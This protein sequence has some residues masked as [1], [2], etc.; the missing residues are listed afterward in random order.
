M[1]CCKAGLK[2]LLLG[3]F[4]E[5]F[6]L[7]SETWDWAAPGLE[8]AVRMRKGRAHRERGLDAEF[9]Q[10]VARAYE[11]ELPKAREQ[12]VAERPKFD[13]ATLQRLADKR[14]RRNLVVRFKL[15]KEAG[16]TQIMRALARANKNEGRRLASQKKRT[17][18]APVRFLNTSCASMRPVLA[19]GGLGESS[20]SAGQGVDQTLLRV[21]PTTPR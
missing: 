2:S 17:D 9:S 13:P 11:S 4:V 20:Q 5:A 10:T 12:I 14:A 18:P 21:M 7:C 1:E 6:T 19:R 8:A 3:R 15:P 16:R